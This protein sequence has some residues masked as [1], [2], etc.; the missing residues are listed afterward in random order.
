MTLATLM[1]ILI[2]GSGLIVGAAL[3]LAVR[4]AAVAGAQR[5][6]AAHARATATA[7]AAAPKRALQDLAASQTGEPLSH[8]HM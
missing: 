8:P 3:V 4:G 2:G 5:L 1:R 6:E 7:T